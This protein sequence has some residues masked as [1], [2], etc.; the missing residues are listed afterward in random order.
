MLRWGAVAPGF[1][2]AGAG[3]PLFDGGKFW[4]EFF[5]FTSVARGGSG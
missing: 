1:D 3:L 4:I 5:D 2:R